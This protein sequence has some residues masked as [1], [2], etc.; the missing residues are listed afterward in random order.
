MHNNKNRVIRGKNNNKWWYVNWGIWVN[1]YYRGKWV[2]WSKEG[3]KITFISTLHLSFF[4]FVG[5]CSSMA[6][7]YM[8]SASDRSTASVLSGSLVV[9]GIIASCCCFWCDPKMLLLRWIWHLLSAGMAHWLANTELSG[10]FIRLANSTIKKQTVP[11]VGWLAL[12]ADRFLL[13]RCWLWRCCWQWRMSEING[14][15]ILI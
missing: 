2:G 9:G 4:F 12:T 3:K 11:C 7:D 13:T 10:E 15:L 8:A 14:K 1:N 6:D 5:G